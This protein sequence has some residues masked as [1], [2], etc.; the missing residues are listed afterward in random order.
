MACLFDGVGCMRILK[1][2]T[3]LELR[4]QRKAYRVAHPRTRHSELGGARM[5]YFTETGWTLP[6]M[7]Q[8]SSD[9]DRD[10]DQGEYEQKIGGLVSKIQSG[11]V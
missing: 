9:F 4:R 2:A 11:P 3:A 6:D 7:K 5:L 1:T 10:Y 8:V